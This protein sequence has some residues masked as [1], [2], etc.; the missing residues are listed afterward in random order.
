MKATERF[1]FQP[2]SFSWVALHPDPKGVV[3]F[4]GGAF[5]GTFPTLFYRYFLRQIFNAGYTVVA[6]PFRFSFRH[7]SIALD[8]LQEEKTIR[9]YLMTLNTGT[10]LQN[11]TE[12]LYSDST[13]YRWI[14]HSL[15]CKYLCLLEILTDSILNPEQSEQLFKQCIQFRQ[16]SYQKILQK[17]RVINASIQGQST[18]L[19]APDISDTQSAIPKPLAFIAH[20]LDRLGWGVLPTRKETQCLID[21]SSLFNLT[22]LIS[23]NRDIIAGSQTDAN[24]EESDVRWFVQQLKK[25]L[26]L[27]LAKELCGKHLE[28]VGIKIGNYLVDLNPLD[29]FIKPLSKHQLPSVVQEFLVALRGDRSKE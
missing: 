28:P 16:S 8:L 5:F 15:G 17:S 3:V 27:P 18:I 20:W 26:H 21:A 1:R 19:I 10:Q 7:W 14:G 6:L 12:T 9:N 23:F 22:A 25:R 13:K 4:I 24:V 11:S 2:V 29:K